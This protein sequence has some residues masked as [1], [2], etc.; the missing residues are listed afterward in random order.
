MLESR[1]FKVVTV[2]P[3]KMQSLEFDN[4]QGQTVSYDGNQTTL[5]L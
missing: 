1:K 4:I 2:T 3:T 5:K